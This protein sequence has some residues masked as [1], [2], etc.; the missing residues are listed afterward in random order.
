MSRKTKA[1]VSLLVGVAFGVMSGLMIYYPVQPDWVG[2]LEIFLMPGYVISLIAN[3]NV[4]DPNPIVA[5]LVNF[6]FYF[7]VAWLILKIAFA[8]AKPR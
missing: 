6:L 3:R 2:R 5:A 1:L 8:D 7:S 4:H